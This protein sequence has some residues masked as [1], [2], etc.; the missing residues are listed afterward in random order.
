MRCLGGTAILCEA[1]SEGLT[2]DC[3]NFRP[4]WTSFGLVFAPVSGWWAEHWELRWIAGEETTA[5]ILW[6][7]FLGEDLGLPE[8]IE[9]T[10]SCVDWNGAHVVLEFSFF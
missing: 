7:G 8:T 10:G 9:F 2:A 6:L 1:T 3:L 5:L 4:D